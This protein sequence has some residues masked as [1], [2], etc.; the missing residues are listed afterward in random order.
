MR[1]LSPILVLLMFLSSCSYSKSIY[2]QL[3]P[4]EGGLEKSFYRLKEVVSPEITDTKVACENDKVVEEEHGIRVSDHASIYFVLNRVKNTVGLRATEHGVTKF[5]AEMNTYIEKLLKT[6]Q[7]EFGK[8]KVR[9]G[10]EV[11]AGTVQE[12]LVGNLSDYAAYS[13]VWGQESGKKRL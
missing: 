10:S 7:T 4:N 3:L 8:D 6:V 5:S 12:A 13:C 11:G 2:L 9:I 1:R